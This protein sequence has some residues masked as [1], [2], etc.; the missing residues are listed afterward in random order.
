MS[1]AWLAYAND[2]AHAILH[3]GIQF[4]EA[5]EDHV[6][7]ELVRTERTFLPS[8]YF[9]SVAL[10]N[11]VDSVAGALAGYRSEP[12]PPGTI[13]HF[14]AQMNLNFLGN[15][16]GEFVRAESR[17]LRKGRRTMVVETV[18]ADPEGVRL[19]HATSTHILA[20]RAVT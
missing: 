3:E 16:N 19:I 7:A 15:S 9:F 11:L 13:L 5:D 2:P 17:W 8:G 10:F 1:G 20:E 12:P 14:M 6:T 4:V 18:A